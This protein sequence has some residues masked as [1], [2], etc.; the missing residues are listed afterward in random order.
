[1]ATKN[2]GEQVDLGGLKPSLS[3][4]AGGRDDAPLLRVLDRELS[5]GGLP[6]S[7][8]IAAWWPILSAIDAAAQK[9]GGWTPEVAAR[10]E[11]FLRSAL[12]FARPGGSALFGPAEVPAE[13][14]PLVHRLVQAMSDPALATVAGR[15]FPQ[16][17]GR[18]PRV[19]AAPP[20]PSAA[21]EGRPLA[22]LRPDWNREGDLIAVDHRDADSP[23]RL[24]LIGAGRDLLGYSWHTL[25]EP[26][27]SGE[28]T[29]RRWSSSYQA[30][31]LEWSSP[32][33]G[34]RTSVL[35]RGRKLAILGEE[36]TASDPGGFAIDRI[37][38]LTAEAEPGGAVVRLGTASRSYGQIL[39]IAFGANDSEPIGL[40][41]NDSAV[42]LETPASGRRSWRAMVMSWDAIRNRKPRTVRRLT[43]TEHR[44]VCPPDRAVAVRLRWGQEDSLLIYRSLA[45]RATRAVL[46]Q[47]ITARF[48]IGLF[49]ADG[50]LTKLLEVED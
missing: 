14:G 47:Q 44:A 43:V 50:S 48:V 8:P 35:L 17:P 23:C 29:L 34:L 13:L 30:D 1:M 46:G 28:A 37:A 31:H 27:A 38:G 2:R 26:N 5:P 4:W 24:Q 32:G 20:L 6:R 21:L 41:V 16:A 45:G 22:I 25:P 49:G 10:V 40:S 9:R 39:S 7:W 19:P 3:R 15:W 33:T 36:S 12:R 11:G 42:R 18:G